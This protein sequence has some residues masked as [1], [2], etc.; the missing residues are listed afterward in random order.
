M[1]TETIVIPAFKSY[2]RKGLTEMRPYVPGE[3]LSDRVSISASDRET[4]SPKAGDWIARNSGDPQDQWL[5][6]KAFFD[7]SGFEVVEP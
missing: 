2:R 6:S 1:S 3:Q 4:G 5:V 7:K